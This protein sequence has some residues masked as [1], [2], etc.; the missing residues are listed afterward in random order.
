MDKNFHY[1]Y[2]EQ[3]TLTPEFILEYERD[4]YIYSCQYD[5]EAEWDMDLTLESTVDDWRLSR[6][7]VGWK[8][9]GQALNEEWHMSATNQEWK[10][11]LEPSTKRTL[12]EVFTFIASQGKRYTIRPAKLLGSN[13]Q[14][15][16]IFLSIKELYASQGH[17]VSKL[18]PSSN[19]IPWLNR[20][21][22]IIYDIHQITPNQLP[23]VYYKNYYIKETLRSTHCL[24]ILGVLPI[25]FLLYVSRCFPLSISW[26]TI[27]FY[28]LTLI[29]SYPYMQKTDQQRSDKINEEIRYKR[30][31]ADKETHW[32]DIKTFSDLVNK[33]SNSP[34]LKTN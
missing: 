11:I 27:F 9:L 18:R 4:L 31:Q 12:R 3:T 25:F 33:M 7:L 8:K 32:E 24:L 17:D 14:K 28:Y 29:L 22:N 2:L 6:D 26:S 34:Y 30:E 5:P 21:N 10:K 13:C 15:A 19:I 16:G 23:M 20:P 1:H